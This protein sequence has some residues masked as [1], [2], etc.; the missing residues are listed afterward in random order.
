MQATWEFKG[1]LS[2]WGNGTAV[3]LTKA[4]LQ[5]A[6]L[7]EGAPVSLHV[8][9]GCIVIRPSRKRETLGEMLA[10]FDPAAHGG[11]VMAFEPVG[12]EAF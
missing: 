8:E 2:R 9:P 6:G 5:R 10:A 3:R 7:E 11:E 4:V 12:K 1:L